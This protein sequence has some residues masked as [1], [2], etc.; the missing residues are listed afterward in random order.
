MSGWNGQK[1]YEIF[2]LH[3]SRLRISSPKDRNLDFPLLAHIQRSL[4]R[5]SFG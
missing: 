5:A 3:F 4:S 2:A 1:R